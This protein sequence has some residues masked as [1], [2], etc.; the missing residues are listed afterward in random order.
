MILSITEV[1]IVQVSV[2]VG[3]ILLCDYVM[4]I[5]LLVAKVVVVCGAEQELNVSGCD[6]SGSG[7]FGYDCG[8]G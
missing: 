5:I 3:V 7:G 8:S 1:V 4:V 2:V 6:C